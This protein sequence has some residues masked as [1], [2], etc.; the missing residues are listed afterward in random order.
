VVYPTLLTS[1]VYP[2]LLGGDANLEEGTE[3]EYLQFD[4]QKKRAQA[5]SDNHE[6]FAAFSLGHLM[7]WLEAREKG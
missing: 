7:A 3:F 6:D 1:H 5:I 2:T 4:L